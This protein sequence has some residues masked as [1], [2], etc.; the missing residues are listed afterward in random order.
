MNNLKESSIKTIVIH[1]YPNDDD[2]YNIYQ[3]VKNAQ[4]KMSARVHLLLLV[5]KINACSKVLR[6]LEVLFHR[7]R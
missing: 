5:I 7:I 4:K 2:L 3:E 1:D 6:V